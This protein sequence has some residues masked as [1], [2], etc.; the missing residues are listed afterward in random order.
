MG[1]LRYPSRRGKAG[2]KSEEEINIA[3]GSEW[4]L[5]GRRGWSEIENQPCLNPLKPDIRR[6]IFC[7]YPTT[8][9]YLSKKGVSHTRKVATY[10]NSSFSVTLSSLSLP[11]ASKRKAPT[12]T[13]PLFL[14]ALMVQDLLAVALLQL[15]ALPFLLPLRVQQ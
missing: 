4:L 8:V 12:A 13:F 15:K 1:K 9:V 7:I 6:T 3:T 2:R 10:D 5:W 14:P 11:E